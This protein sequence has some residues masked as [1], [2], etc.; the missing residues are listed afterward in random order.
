M[1]QTS[2]Q[3]SNQAPEQPFEQSFKYKLDKAH[4]QECFEESAS[5]LTKNDYKLMMFFAAVGGLVLF[6][7]NEYY[8]VAFFMITLAIV[9]F[10]SLKYRKTW[11]VW[12][13]L[14][15][16][17]GNSTVTVTIDEQGI[18]SQ[19]LHVNA[20]ILWTEVE[21]IEETDKALIIRHAGG[22]SYLS[23]SHLSDEAI[24]F[25]TNASKLVT[26]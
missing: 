12:R 10:F 20:K 3:A 26:G 11:W 8:Y 18:S 25:I 22:S 4:L 19:S 7:E 6:I 17:S 5:P 13:Q 14:L 1:S 2:Q 21:S 23:K 16:K 9:E 24:L 15:G